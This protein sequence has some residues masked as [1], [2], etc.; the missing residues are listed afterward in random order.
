MI[1]V[2]SLELVK[3]YR[4]LFFRLPLHCV[5]LELAGRGTYVCAPGRER[6]STRGLV[7]LQNRPARLVI[8][9]VGAELCISILRNHRNCTSIFECS[10]LYV[11]KVIRSCVGT[12]LS[13]YRGFCAQTV[14]YVIAEHARMVCCMYRAA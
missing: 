13:H 2:L 14:R 4:V 11:C 3:S 12:S 6:V 7:P 1:R 9:A 8:S 10:L 5:A